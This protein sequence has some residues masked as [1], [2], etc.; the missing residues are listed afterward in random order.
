[1]QD[2]NHTVWLGNFNRHHLHWDK[3]ADDRLF[4]TD[5][6]DEADNLISA[7]KDVEL[8]LALPPKIPTYKHNVTKKWTRLNHVF[9]S[10]HSFNTLISCEALSWNLGPNTDHLPKVMNVDLI[11]A[12]ASLKSLPNFQNVD[13]DKFSN[14]LKSKLQAFDV[15]KPMM[16]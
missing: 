2:C 16:N 14:I 1:M 7:V 11:S 5:A 6:I 13:W 3:K 9:L 4:T 10:D 15:P 8:N 12:K